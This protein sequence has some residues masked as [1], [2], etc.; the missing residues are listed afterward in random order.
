VVDSLYILVNAEVN[1]SSDSREV[2]PVSLIYLLRCTL[3]VSSYIITFYFLLSLS[4]VDAPKTY[5]MGYISL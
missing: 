4:L 1:N 5:V 3:S 2:R